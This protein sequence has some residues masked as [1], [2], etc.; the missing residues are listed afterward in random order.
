[1]EVITNNQCRDTFID[2]L[3]VS[4][5]PV[6]DF[7][8]S[9]VCFADSSYITNTSTVASGNIANYAWEFS[10]G[11]SSNLENPSVFYPDSGQQFAALEVT[12]DSG[13]TNLIQKYFYKHPRFEL[14]FTFN[15]TC[16]GFGQTFTNTT[17]LEGGSFTDTFWYTSDPAH[18]A[19]TYNYTDTFSGA[20]TYDV[21]LVM[22][23]DSFCRDTLTQTVVV[24]PLAEA[25]FDFTNTCLGDSTAFA[26]MSTVSTGT[27]SS[28][29][30]FG[31]G[32]TSSDEDPKH[33][34]L[35]GGSKMVNLIILTDEGCVTDTTQ[36]VLITFPEITSIQVQD[37]CEGDSLIITADTIQG[38]DSFSSYSW[39][40][41][42]ESTSDAEVRTTY[43]SL[44]K[45]IVTLDV[46]TKNGCAIS[47]TDSFI[48]QAKPNPNFLVSG[49]CEGF[50][51]EPA[52]NSTIAAPAVLD[53][54]QWYL[55]NVFQS[56]DQN[57]TLSSGAAGNRSIKLIVTAD[58]GCVDSIQ[59]LGLVYPLPVSSYT[60][61]QMCFGDNNTL[62]STSSISSGTIDNLYWLVDGV[63]F[64]SSSINTEFSTDGPFDVQ[65]ISES[66]RGCRD[67]LDNTV[68]VDPL[69]VLS[70]NIQ[71]DSGCVPLDVDV[72]S[73]SSISSGSI[74]S[75]TFKWG[76]GSLNTVDDSSHT[77]TTPG[78]YTINIIGESDKGCIDSIQITDGV[79]VFDNPVADFSFSPTEPSTLTE[80]V[81]LKDSSQ[82]NISTWDWTI[83]DGTTESGAIVEH[84]FSDTGSYAVTLAITDEN[85]CE[86]E[87]TKFIY[88]NADLFVFIPNSFTPNG[89][90]LNDQFGLA[91]VTA[92]VSQMEMQI[93]NRWG[94]LIFESTDI[95]RRWDGTYRGEPAQVGVYVYKVK[96]TN[97]KQTKWFFLDGE[98][99]LLDTQ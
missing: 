66:D 68:T 75:Y 51:L 13:C 9:D 39:T 38:L 91:G 85:G 52:E 41:G 79:T 69:P 87:T 30:S 47:Q 6:A 99:H 56:T 92:G 36:E 76:D 32:S 40:Y 23:Q 19:N 96:F 80:F 37:I 4:P 31:D 84:N 22:E 7:D 72:A 17:L 26:N 82:G 53:T 65:L 21:S 93:F 29:W 71:Q 78:S 48:T 77:Y 58:N 57:P 89:D 33:L 44:G 95:N 15:D 62:T 12:S 27:F 25:A 16:L 98:I 60:S 2:S 49:V 81:V 70:F 64:T 74:A 45:S 5:I 14:G 63:S 11:T 86:D 55:D 50:D 18:S 97:P 46:I 28:S 3:M 54:Y 90:G 73:L 24:H 61:S 35:S 34:Y 8:I 20:N 94:E 59:K 67:T 83:S 42:A 88:V 10:N 1:M 43:A